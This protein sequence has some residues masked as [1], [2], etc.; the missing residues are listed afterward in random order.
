M[1]SVSYTHLWE[2][3]GAKALRTEDQFIFFTTHAQLK[4]SITQ[5]SFEC[6]TAFFNQLIAAVVHFVSIHDLTQRP[7]DLSKGCPRFPRPF[8]EVLFKPGQ[9]QTYSLWKKMLHLLLP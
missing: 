8:P 6:I 5:G 1:R 9:G 7:L 2:Q 3:A 4:G